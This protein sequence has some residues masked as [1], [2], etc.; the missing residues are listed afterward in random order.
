MTSSWA[1]GLP[2]ACPPDSRLPASSPW[3]DSCLLH[4]QSLTRNMLVPL[5]GH[6]PGPQNQQ[7]WIRKTEAGC[8][9]QPR[10][11]G[12]LS[13]LQPGPQGEAYIS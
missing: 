8:I 11:E 2:L 13:P 1:L 7:E 9:W 3:S 6:G 4:G 10:E 12:A 5:S